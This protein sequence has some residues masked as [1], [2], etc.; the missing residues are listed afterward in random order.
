MVEDNRINQAIVVDALSKMRFIT[1]IAEDGVKALSLLNKATAS[2]RY[3]LI[4]MDC[5]LPELNGYDTS[6]AIRSG[7]AG[8]QHT[9][10]PIIAMTANNS[11]VDK[12]KCFAAGMNDF[13]SKPLQYNRLKDKI[14]QCLS[15]N[16]QPQN[17]YSK[18]REVGGGVGDET[19][20]FLLSHDC[21]GEIDS[22]LQKQQVQFENNIKVWHKAQFIERISGDQRLATILIDLFLSDAP[23]FITAI[24]QAVK[25]QDVKSALIATHQLKGACKNIS[26][27][28]V[29]II[30]E[31]I[32]LW[33]KRD[34][35]DKY[36]LLIDELL[37]E[38]QQLITLLQQEKLSE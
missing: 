18:G 34:I 6:R 2:C 15:L 9:K 25:A 1:D 33:F 7:K 16:Q 20:E 22:V 35:S 38:S 14:Y 32:E 37:M 27:P 3:H 10:V 28:R 36:P 17:Y 19:T 30:I 29:V 21:T 11:S 24:Q 13:T 26:A 4:L 8:E 12:A 31:A 5:H 23:E